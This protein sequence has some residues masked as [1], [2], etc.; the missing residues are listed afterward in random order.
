MFLLFIHFPLFKFIVW[1]DEVELEQSM[2]TF[3]CNF[4]A[5]IVK[6]QVNLF[7]EKVQLMN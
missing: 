3:L 7:A 6:F 5:K 4:D 2:I 1:F